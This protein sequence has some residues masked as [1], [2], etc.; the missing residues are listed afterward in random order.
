VDDFAF[1]KRHTYGTVLVDLERRRPVDVLPDRSAETFAT[2]LRAHPGV[3]VIA[4]DRSTEYARGAREGAPNAL[5]V[6][7][8]WHLLQNLRDA[9]E[10]AITTLL[11]RLCQWLSQA[12]SHTPELSRLR[13]K[14]YSTEEVA[15]RDQSREARYARYVQVK[16]LKAQ[17]VSN[18]E[19]ARQ[20]NISRAVVIRFVQSPQ[21]PERA[22][23]QI[24]PSILDPYVAYLQERWEA[25]CSNSSQLWRE[26]Q[27]QGYRGGRIQVARWMRQKRTAP[28]STTPKK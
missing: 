15:R 5:Q 18:R 17:G 25:G 19:I 28:A 9:L 14:P 27:A 1:R 10:R 6:A 16:H 8:R 13:L 21:F 22:A 24:R 7:D 2:W 26:I 4:R 11:P 3:E 23:Y 20:L 12:P